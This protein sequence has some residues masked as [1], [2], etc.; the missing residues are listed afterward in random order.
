MNFDDY[1]YAQI[2]AALA[3]VIGR[4]FLVLMATLLGS[5]LGGMT[6]TRSLA[7]LL[8]GLV[9]FPSYSLGSLFLSVG[10]VVLPLI[11]LYTIISTRYEWAMRFTLICTVL[12]WWNIH[13]TIRWSLY[14]SPMVKQEKQVQADLNQ[15]M[16]EANEK[17]K[18]K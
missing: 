12:M 6:A 14:D 4:I 3:T 16:K 7:G 11:L 10:M 17:L 2:R 8:L 15:A 18:R 9:G 1:P 13:R 5:M